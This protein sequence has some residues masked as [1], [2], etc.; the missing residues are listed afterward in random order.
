MSFN[1]PQLKRKIRQ[2]SPSGRVPALVDGDL[3][4]WDSL[5][6]VE[7]LAEKFPDKRLWPPGR[8]GPGGGPLDVR[9]DARGLRHPA[10]PPW[11]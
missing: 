9:R 11:S 8:A 4:V 3:V 2:V 7:Y 10:R 5:A 6:I 1:D